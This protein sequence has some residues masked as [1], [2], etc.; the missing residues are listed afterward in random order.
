MILILYDYAAYSSSSCVM[1]KANGTV[2]ATR[3][4]S[5]YCIFHS[6]LCLLIC[7]KLNVSSVVLIRIEPFHGLEGP[8]LDGEGPERSSGRS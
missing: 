8:C 3:L 7:P 4:D 6:H 5:S 1:D 2:S